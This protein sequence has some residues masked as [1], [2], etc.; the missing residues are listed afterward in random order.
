MTAVVIAV[1]VL[2]TIQQ[3]LILQA[4][5][6]YLVSDF[7]NYLSLL[8]NARQVEF[9]SS[10]LLLADANIWLDSELSFTVILNGL[11]CGLAQTLFVHR[12]Y[13]CA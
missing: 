4:T 7:G 8:F 1:M 10:F 9:A 11:V 6:T 5:Y 13:H 2:D 12:A 3:V